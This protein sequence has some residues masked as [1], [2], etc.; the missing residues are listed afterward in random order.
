MKKLVAPGVSLIQGGH[1]FRTA[2]KFIPWCKSDPTALPGVAVLAG[3]PG[4]NAYVACTLKSGQ[5]YAYAF[6]TAPYNTPCEQYLA[7][8]HQYPSAN[9]RVGYFGEWFNYVSRKNVYG[10]APIT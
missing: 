10:K 1:S 5:R 3:L 6:F 9:G 7:T 2:H 8:F 4:Y